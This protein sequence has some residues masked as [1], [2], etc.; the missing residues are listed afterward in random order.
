M[1][2]RHSDSLQK[3]QLTLSQGMLKSGDVNINTDDDDEMT[4]SVSQ[5]RVGVTLSD[6]VFIALPSYQQR[7]V[8]GKQEIDVQRNTCRWSQLG[9]QLSAR[10]PYCKTGFLKSIQLFCDGEDK[11]A[12][13]FYPAI[14]YSAC[15]KS[16]P[17]THKFNE[18]SYKQCQSCLLLGFYIQ[19][20][21][22]YWYLVI[23][24]S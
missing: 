6:S 18:K 10:P 4:T 23:P 3:S 14:Q 2:N 9:S 7:A 20:H 8:G 24:L 19:R 5:K 1:L 15:Q 13:F 12:D 17:V 22:Q 11:Y 16:W 21:K